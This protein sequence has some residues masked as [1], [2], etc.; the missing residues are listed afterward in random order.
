MLRLPHQDLQATCLLVPSGGGMQSE[1]ADSSDP[2]YVTRV[3]LRPMA[4]PL[5]LGFAGLAG[6]SVTVAGTE[7]GW[8]HHS[9]MMHAG[10]IVL[11]VAP[12]LQV[13]A[14]VFGF[15]T[16][17]AV[18]A[19]GMGVLAATWGIIGAVTVTSRPGATSHALGSL[20]FMS[21]PI[22]LVSAAVAAS[23]KLVPAMVMSLTGLRFIVTGVYEFIPDA[24]WKT[25]AGVVGL[26]VAAAALYGV[27]SL[28]I[29]GMLGSPLLPTLRIRAG[30]KAMTGDFPAQVNGIANEAGVRKQL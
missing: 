29:E 17:D 24:G 14:C 5:P 4:N 10:I 20:L 1:L 18:T 12:L 6:A 19:T 8:I 23:G 2:L 22:V 11:I 21:G 25:A 27:A 16:R 15:L 13:I 28:E 30:R 26:V 9:D 7:L 3:F